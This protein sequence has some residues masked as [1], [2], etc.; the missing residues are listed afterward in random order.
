MNQKEV[1]YI[2]HKVEVV[3]G[4][5]MKFI[6]GSFNGLPNLFENLFNLISSFF[7]LNMIKIDFDEDKGLNIEKNRFFLIRLR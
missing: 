1:S 7:Q 5:R 3:N 6:F 4:K 2:D